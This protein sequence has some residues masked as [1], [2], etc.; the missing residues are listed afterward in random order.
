MA[1]ENCYLRAQGYFYYG[2]VTW[3]QGDLLTIVTHVGDKKI[4][5]KRLVGDVYPVV[6]MAL[7]RRRWTMREWPSERL[8]ALH[9]RLM[10]LLLEDLR[11]LP[12][13]LNEWLAEVSAEVGDLSN[14]RVD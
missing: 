4:A 2:Q 6:A 5:A 7:G 3:L 11:G 8:D 9:E 12:L 14:H 10:D 13:I 1:P